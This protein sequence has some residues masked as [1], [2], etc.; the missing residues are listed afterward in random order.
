LIKDK[1]N[2]I[3]LSEGTA[4]PN[5]NT[6]DFL[7][8]DMPLAIH[9]LLEKSARE[10]HRSKNQEAIVVLTDGLTQRSKSLKRPVPFKWGKNLTDDL[11][12]KSIDIGRE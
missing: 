12:R 8:Q 1:Q 5:K 4:M 7:I 9:K 2:T 3:I 11:I 6:R 10:H